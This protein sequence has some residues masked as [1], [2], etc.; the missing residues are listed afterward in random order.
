MLRVAV[1]CLQAA[2]TDQIVAVLRRD[3]DFLV[4]TG[5][6]VGKPELVILEVDEGDPDQ[7][8]SDIR[9][10]AEEAPSAEVF[11][12]ASRSDPSLILE[13]FRCGAKE[14]LPQPVED[15]VL[16]QAL[17]RFRQRVVRYRN[18]AEL[19]EGTLVAIVGTKAGVG[20]TSVAVNVARAI[21]HE[22]PGKRVAVIDLDIAGSD[23]SLFMSL[24]K[25]SGIKELVKDISRLDETIAT[26]SLSNPEP[27]IFVLPSGYPYWSAETP[28]RGSIIHIL[29]LMIQRFDV[30]LLDCGSDVRAHVQE[31]LDLASR[32]WLVTTLDVA[33]VRRAKTLLDKELLGKMEP[34]VVELVVNRYLPDDESLMSKTEEILQR[35]SF[36][37]IPNDDEA[38]R[39]SV[40]T[41]SS[42][43]SAAPRS[44]LAASYAKQARQLF[45]VKA[46]ARDGRKAGT[47][48]K[49]NFLGRLFSR[50][51]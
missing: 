19:K 42:L 30:I 33:S 28:D 27:G 43:M 46:D 47:Q 17:L 4:L 11:V 32:I 6:I 26:T 1:N 29:S 5:R 20:V 15:Y 22:Q 7:V 45:A 10:V 37:R 35:K 18:G 14:F 23:L 39:Q 9:R 31:A 49:T 34:S 44:S 8:L 36:W 41:A 21:V 38:S 50:K 48:A 12:T 51:V 3:P 13:V 16:E 2:V 40:L 24:D 25:P